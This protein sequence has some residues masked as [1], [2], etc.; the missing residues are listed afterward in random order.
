MLNEGDPA[1]DLPLIDLSGR[2]VMLSQT[3]SQEE[4]A[5]LVFLRHLG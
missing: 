2:R 1:P 4:S 5:L 3:W